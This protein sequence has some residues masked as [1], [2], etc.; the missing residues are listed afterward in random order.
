MSN[1]GEVQGEEGE[2]ED[3]L[4]PHLFQTILHTWVEGTWMN[5]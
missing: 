5:K 4:N 2:G 1:G 3:L